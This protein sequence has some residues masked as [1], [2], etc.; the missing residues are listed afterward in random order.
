MSAWRVHAEVGDGGRDGADSCRQ[1]LDSSLPHSRRAG[2]RGE[3]SIRRLLPNRRLLPKAL[4][5]ERGERR[6]VCGLDRMPEAFAACG[7]VALPGIPCDG[8]VQVMQQ[9]RVQRR[10]WLHAGMLRSDSGT[11]F[12]QPSMVL[13]SGSRC[14]SAEVY[15]GELR[16]HSGFEEEEGRGR[17]ADVQLREHRGIEMLPIVPKNAARQCR[18]NQSSKLILRKQR[19]DGGTARGDGQERQRTKSEGAGSRKSSS[20]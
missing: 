7:E 14:D 16:A 8:L 11:N 9:G 18:K 15:V 13:R 6:K 10:M 17:C 1:G 2:R 12:L 5:H 3:G 19:R 20:G 4:L